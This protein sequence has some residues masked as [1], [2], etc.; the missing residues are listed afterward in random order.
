MFNKA[1]TSDFCD[2]C[3]PFNSIIAP[4]T[5]ISVYIKMKTFSKIMTCLEVMFDVKMLECL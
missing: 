1:L 2:K 4:F 5:L 3:A